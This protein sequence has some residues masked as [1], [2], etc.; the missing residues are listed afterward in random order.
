M[1]PSLLMWGISTFI[2]VSG[3]MT[4][5]CDDSPPSLKHAAYKALEYRT[6]TMLTCGC[7]RGFRRLNSVMRCAGNS[8]HASWQNKCQCVSTSSKRTERQVTPKPEEEKAMQSLTLPGD[9]GNL[10]GH[11]REPPSWDHEDSERIYHFVVGQTVHYQCAPGFRALRRGSAQSV[12]KTVSG[13]TQWTRPQLKC[14]SDREDG[15]FP[16]DDEDEPE[17]STLALPGRDTSRP[18]MTAGT[19]DSHKHTEVA[20]TMESFLFTSEYQIAVAGCVL[21]LV[22]VLLLSGLT[23]QR[24]WRKSRRTI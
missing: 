17:A 11:C 12:C 24:R 16:A 10:P 21:L 9:Q 1:E 7:E 13:K 18:L 2:T 8:S 19:T 4:D 3:H 6:G 14:I 15:Q 23:W 20:T 22:S 5:L